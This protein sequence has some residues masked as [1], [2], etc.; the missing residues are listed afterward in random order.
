MP[1]RRRRRHPDPVLV[2]E[3]RIAAPLAALEERLMDASSSLNTVASGLGDIARQIRR[4]AEQVADRTGG[5]D[6]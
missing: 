4:M 1:F 3:R 2:A 6:G 5:G